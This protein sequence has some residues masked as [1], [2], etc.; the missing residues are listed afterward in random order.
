M[1]NHI[2]ITCDS[3]REQSVKISKCESMKKQ[4]YT[5]EWSVQVKKEIETG[6]GRIEKK[7]KDHPLSIVP[8]VFIEQRREGGGTEMYYR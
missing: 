7:R 4:V 1:Y 2:W 3:E 8:V 5:A 6:K